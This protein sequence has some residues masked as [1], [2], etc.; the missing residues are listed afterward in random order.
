[1]LISNPLQSNGCYF[2]Q[3]A[4]FYWKPTFQRA[5]YCNG[6]KRCE[7]WYTWSTSLQ[8]RRGLVL[9]QL[10][11]PCNCR[12]GFALTSKPS[13]T[14]DLALYWLDEEKQAAATCTLSKGEWEDC[15]LVRL[16]PCWIAHFT[17]AHVSP[18]VNWNHHIVN[19]RVLEKFIHVWE[20]REKRN[21]NMIG[22][23]NM[24]GSI[25]KKVLINMIR[26]R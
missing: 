26:C 23:N 14:A 4:Y 10:E 3:K 9:S 19:R 16:L 1:M 12:I 18:S 6:I 17:V 13:T 25:I 24:I 8:R 21:N 2:L 22:F 7:M 20:F 15:A 11:A 5:D